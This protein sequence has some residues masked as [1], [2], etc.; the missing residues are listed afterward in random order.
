VRLAVVALGLCSL[1]CGLVLDLDPPDV[2]PDAGRMDASAADAGRE[3]EDAGREEDAGCGVC[4]DDGNPCTLEHC[5]EGACTSTNAELECDLDGDACTQDRCVDGTCSPNGDVTCPQGQHCE[6]GACAC[7]VGG[8]RPCGDQC[9]TDR[10]GTCC[11]DSECAPPTVCTGAGGFC[12][13]PS[14]QRLCEDRCIDAFT[15]CCTSSDCGSERF[16]VDDRCVCPPDTIDCGGVSCAPSET[17]CEPGETLANDCGSICLVKQCNDACQA[18]CVLGPAATCPFAVS[19]SFC[20][21]GR[22][23]TCVACALSTTIGGD[24]LSDDDC[25]L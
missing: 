21:A 3:E 2:R 8:L 13:C 7:D 15:G 18:E 17:F 25:G 14:G 1:G 11:E 23:A 12:A 6:A 10:V 24:C 22:C 5:V 19:T 4:P 20:N 16:C 9:I